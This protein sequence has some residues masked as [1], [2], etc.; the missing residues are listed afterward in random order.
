MAELKVAAIRFDGN[1]KL[2][3]FT[4][5]EDTF[6]KGDKVLVKLKKW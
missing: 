3:F 2:Y 4:S 1:K 6:N 5:K